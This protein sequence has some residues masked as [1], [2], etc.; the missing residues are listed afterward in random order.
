LERMPRETYGGDFGRVKKNG[1]KKDI[2]EESKFLGKSCLDAAGKL[3][4]K[5]SAHPEVK[6]TP[7][8]PLPPK[9]LNFSGTVL[10]PNGERLAVGEVRHHGSLWTAK[11]NN[12]PGKKIRTSVNLFKPGWPPVTPSITTITKK[13]K[14][15]KNCWAGTKCAAVLKKKKGT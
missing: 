13:K 12:R 14:N 6:C 3:H 8:C 5:V 7:K 10:Q 15:R 11:G 1:W 2:Q 9:G 4:F